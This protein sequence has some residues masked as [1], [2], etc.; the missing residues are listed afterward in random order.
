MKAKKFKREEEEQLRAIGFV[1]DLKKEQRRLE[2]QKKILALVEYKRLNGNMNIKTDYV[3]PVDHPDASLRGIK[4]GKIISYL[5]YKK[6]K[7]EL[8]KEYEDQL[9]EIGFL[10]EKPIE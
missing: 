3:F 6:K 10:W 5:R 1:F 4:L 2:F 7:E 8:P 9:N